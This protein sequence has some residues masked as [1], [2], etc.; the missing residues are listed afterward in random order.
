MM[1]HVALITT[2]YPDRNPGSEAAGSFV[3][4]FAEALSKHLRI[5]VLAPSLFQGE[6]HRHPNL[7]VCRFAVPRLPLSLLTPGKPTHWPLIIKTLFAGQKA[8]QHLADQSKP[9]YVFALWTL[10]SGHWA[11]SVKKSHGI[12][13]SVWALGSDIWTLG[14]IP[15]VRNVVRTVLRDATVRFADGYQLQKDVESIAGLPCEF[16]PSARTLPSN[17]KKL[18]GGPPYNLAYLGRWHPNKGT[19][20]LCEA[21]GTLAAEDWDKIQE[22]RICGGGPLE[23]QIR[24]EV[25]ALKA[26]GRP[27]VLRGYLSKDEAVE[28]LL[29]ADYVLIPSRIESIPVIFSDALQC[30]CPVVCMPVGDLP[31]LVKN[32]QVGI[33]A[34]DVSVPIFAAAIR[35]ILHQP[36]QL[37]KN[38]MDICAREFSMAGI[39]ENFLRKCSL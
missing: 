1:K 26:N 23:S 20:L 38:G 17:E 24:K 35:E 22:V 6:E 25:E 16:L 14:R 28:L 9:D 33:L 12:S 13:Y 29:W 5:T 27:V 19:D 30:R 2:S 8:I 21:L 32:Y 10:P 18:K 7:T 36:P 11:R 15:V 34:D 39:I 3:E 37:F 4:D 31:R